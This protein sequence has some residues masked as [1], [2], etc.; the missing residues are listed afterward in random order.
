MNTRTTSVT[1]N[2]RSAF[3][4]PGWDETL[5]A[6]QYTVTTDEEQLDT[7]FPAF[8]RVATRIELRKGA[9]TQFLTISPED[10]ATALIKD[11]ESAPPA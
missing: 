7:S 9:L 10:L 4:L 2:F 6:G 1:I 5:P 8:H 11:H 3:A